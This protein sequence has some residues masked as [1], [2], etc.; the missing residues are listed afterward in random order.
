[1]DDRTDLHLVGAPSPVCRQCT[2]LAS[3]RSTSGLCATC[4]RWAKIDRLTPGW[5]PDERRALVL[6]VSATTRTLPPDDAE[7]LFVVLTSLATL[8]H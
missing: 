2:G 7:E 5:S 4:E 6:V 1:M 8:L 3:S